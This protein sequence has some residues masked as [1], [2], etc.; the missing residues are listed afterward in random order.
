MK[1]ISNKNS[2]LR[3]L[4]DKCATVF[5]EKILAIKLIES[6]VPKK[7]LVTPLSYLGNLSIKICTS[8]NCVMQNKPSY[9]NFWFVFQT[10]CQ[11]SNFL[12]FKDRKLD[13]YYA[14]ALPINFSVVVAMLPIMKKL[15][16]IL[17]S[18]CVATWEFRHSLEKVL[19]AMMILPLKNIFYSAITHLILKIYPSLL[20]TTT[21]LKLP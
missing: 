1:S 8:I 12:T 20:P 9:C 6:K 7:D 13:H 5:L 17:R 19:K 4:V 18:E 3:D 15:N 14:L 16:N 11:I 2:Y 10:K 21:I